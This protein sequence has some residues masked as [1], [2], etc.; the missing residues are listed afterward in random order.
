VKLRGYLLIFLLSSLCISSCAQP[1][2][3]IQDD[4]YRGLLTKPDSQAAAFFV[5]A[6]GSSNEYIRQAAAEELANMG[7]ELSAKTA[8]K[9]KKEAAGSWAAAF[10]AAGK[11]ADREKALAF[12]LGFDQEAASGEA[13]LYV[14]R[15]FEKQGMSFSGTEAAAVEAHFASSRLRYN[16]A[17]LFFRMFMEEDEWPAQI[18]DLFLKYPELINDLGRTFQYTASGSEGLNLFLQWES[19]LT[20]ETAGP[21]NLRFRLLFYAARI[22][23]RRGYVDQG[24]SLFEKAQPLAPES[25]QADACIWYILDMSLREPADVFTR[26]LEQFIQYWHNAAYYDDIMEKF[27]HALASKRDWKNLIRAFDI[28]QKSAAANSKAAYAWV[29][30][31][32]IEEKFISGE[33]LRTA[34]SAANVPEADPSAATASAAAEAATAAFLRIAYNAEDTSFY[35]RSQSASALGEPFLE[36][37]QENAPSGKPPPANRSSPASQL[38]PANWPSPVLQFLLGF[39]N[40]GAADFSLRYIALLEKE[41]SIVELRSTAQA[42]ER[43]GMYAQSIRLV[44]HYIGKDGYPG[45]REDMELFFPRPFSELVEKYAQESGIAPSLLFGLIRTESA[46]QSGIVSRAGAVGLTQ[47]MPDTA[48]E[49]AG[50][51]RRAGGP[52]YLAAEDGLDLGDPDLNIHIGSYYLNYLIGRFDDTLLSLLAY[53]GGMNRVRRWRAR[54]TLPADLFLETI[55]LFETR[56]YGRKVMAAAAVYEELYYKNR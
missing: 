16:E 6:L 13:R 22:A 38:S 1:Q 52:D 53:N 39:F 14:M 8:E 21:D 11:P 41:L 42:L 36:L 31:R 12:L 54:N 33:E 17:L 28:I 44:S 46:F 51:I 49:M 10:A 18:P 50:R 34:S 27:L 45:A 43:A 5:K 19:N 40:Y 32:A 47:L 56:D 24:I 4:F 9:V 29:I 37:P 20:D 23:R 25:E 2:P 7:T 35:Y 15:E 26:R 55:T 48:R 3:Q 30:A